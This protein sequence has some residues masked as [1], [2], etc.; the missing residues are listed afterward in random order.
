MGCTNGSQAKSPIQRNIMP[1]EQ[2]IVGQDRQ[3]EIN[4]NQRNGDENIPKFI[5]NPVGGAS[6]VSPYN[7]NESVNLNQQKKEQSWKQESNDQHYEMA[8]MFQSKMG[9][10]TTEVQD[11]NMPKRQE[12]QSYLNKPYDYGGSMP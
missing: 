12:T 2:A 3:E 11:G 7:P 8:N 4:L 5:T 9:V 6:E 10:P 1:K